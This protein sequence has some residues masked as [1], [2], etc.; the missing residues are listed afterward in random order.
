MINDLEKSKVI[1]TDDLGY[2]TLNDTGDEV[3]LKDLLRAILVRNACVSHI[4]GFLTKT[5]VYIDEN[6]NTNEKLIQL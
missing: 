6:L 1:T 5:L 3:N 2:V 4:K